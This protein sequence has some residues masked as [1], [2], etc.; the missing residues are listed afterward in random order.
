MTA[1]TPDAFAEAIA[2]LHR[3]GQTWHVPLLQAV[4]QG[5]IALWLIPPG[6]RVPVR[7]LDPTASPLPT[8]AVLCGDD[9]SDRCRPSDFP[10]A[11]RWLR[12]ARAIMLHGTGGR[13]EHYA[14]AVGAA[15]RVRRVLVVDLPSRAVPEWFELARR[16]APKAH[17]LMILPPPGQAH[18]IAQRLN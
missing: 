3:A 7:A 5:L 6:E 15:L 13:E 2:L 11:V 12:W 14:A 18:P 17:G 10:Q 1:Q 8:V 4:R 9:E 16:V